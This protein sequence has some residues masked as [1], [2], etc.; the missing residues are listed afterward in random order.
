MLSNSAVVYNVISEDKITLKN[1]KISWE[2][3]NLKAF[4]SLFS[5]P[6]LSRI[7]T[8]NNANLTLGCRKKIINKFPTFP[9]R[10]GGGLR[11]RENSLLFFFFETFP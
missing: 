11:V 10:G 5:W 4:T 7:A 2:M 6:Q 1:L 9:P 8:K 3:F